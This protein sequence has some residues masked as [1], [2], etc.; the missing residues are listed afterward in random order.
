L[1][2]S[3]LEYLYFKYLII[4]LIDKPVNAFMLSNNLWPLSVISG[5]ILMKLRCHNSIVNLPQAIKVTQ[6]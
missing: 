5:L 4:E 3:Y 1:L 2:F 6:A